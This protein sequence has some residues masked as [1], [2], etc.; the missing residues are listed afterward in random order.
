MKRPLFKSI[1]LTC[2]TLLACAT[3][4]AQDD[5]EF[6][7][8]WIA[9]APPG[10][11]VMAAYMDIKNTSNKNLIITPPKSGDFKKIEFH[12]TLHENGMAKMQRLAELTIPANSTVNLKQGSYHMMLFN[13]AKKMK[14][15]DQSTLTFQIKDARKNSVAI[16]VVAPVKKPVFEQMDHSHH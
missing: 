1:S 13:P 11:Q 4:F 10:S 8:A 14:A 12:R 3:A 6:D 9:E 16:K 15:G 2:I 5:I 7:N